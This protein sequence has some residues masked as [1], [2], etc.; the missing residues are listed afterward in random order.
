MSYLNLVH[1]EKFGIEI[2]VVWY[3]HQ[4]TG[5]ITLRLCLYSLILR[6]F[7]LR[8]RGNHQEKGIQILFHPIAQSFEWD[9]ETVMSV[10]GGGD[11]G[12]DEREDLPQDLLPFRLFR[13]A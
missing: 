4:M 3:L 9:E 7:G 12:R 2:L 13:V 5:K 11:E 1:R 6:Y 8:I 10:S